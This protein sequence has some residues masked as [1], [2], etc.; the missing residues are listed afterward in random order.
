MKNRDLFIFTHAEMKEEVQENFDWILSYFPDEEINQ[1]RKDFEN[2]RRKP[3]VE[4]RVKYD[5]RG[6]ITHRP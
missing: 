2:N 5:T 3:N 1:K 4:D 6:K